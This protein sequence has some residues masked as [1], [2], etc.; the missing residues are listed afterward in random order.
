MSGNY[1]IYNFYHCNRPVSVFGSEA[2]QLESERE[3]SLSFTGDE[4]CVHASYQICCVHD[5]NTT[6]IIVCV[7]EI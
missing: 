3:F 1:D 2:L 5:I 7:Y 4:V 6:Y